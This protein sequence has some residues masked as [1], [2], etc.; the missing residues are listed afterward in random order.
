V[1]DGEHSAGGIERRTAIEFYADPDNAD[2]AFQFSVYKDASIRAML[3]SV[4]FTKCAYCESDIQATHPPDVEHYR[5]KGEVILGTGEHRKPGYYWLAATWTNLLPSCIDCNRQRRQERADGSESG[6]M[7]KGNLFPLEDEARRATE[8][9]GEADEAPLLLDPCDP[10][11]DPANHLDFFDEGFVRPA[12][13]DGVPSA[14]G[15]A[16]IEVMGLM[17]LGLA[18]RRADRRVWAKLLKRDLVEAASEHEADPSL[19]LPRERLRRYLVDLKKTLN[20]RSEY[21]TMVR[22]ELQPVLDLLGIAP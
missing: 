20:E 22:Q 7:G 6:L 14:K 9:G 11:D 5:P 8:P 16:T 13:I 15:A 17:R 19:P 3:E 1:V 2:K 10:N 12:R 4:F 18:N 21:V